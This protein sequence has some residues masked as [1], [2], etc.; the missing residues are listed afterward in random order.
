[1]MNKSICIAFTNPRSLVFLNNSR[2]CPAIAES[3]EVEPEEDSNKPTII[4]IAPNAI[5]TYVPQFIVLK[6]YK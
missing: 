2:S 1:M 3:P 6:L 5:N 4:E